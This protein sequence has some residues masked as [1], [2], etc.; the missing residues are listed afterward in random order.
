MPNPTNFA[1]ATEEHLPRYV[2]AQMTGRSLSTVGRWS[3][4]ASEPTPSSALRL[5]QIL[6]ICEL[7]RDD[8][9]PWRPWAWFKGMNPRLRFEEPSALVAVGRISEV[10]RAAERFVAFPS[11]QLHHE[12]AEDPG[13]TDPQEAA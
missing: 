3:R 4:G 9:R 10:R 6:E 5:S 12:S 13:P 2:I 8:D 11:D 1:R 7:L